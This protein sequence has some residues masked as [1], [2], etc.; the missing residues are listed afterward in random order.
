[1]WNTQPACN[2]VVIDH[3]AMKALVCLEDVPGE[4]S[5]GQEQEKTN[6]L[7]LV[8]TFPGVSAATGQIKAS[9]PCFLHHDASEKPSIFSAH[10]LT[11]PSEEVL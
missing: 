4:T 3:L 7:D 11:S 2:S 5:Q 9:E 6:E 10:R 1:M 8:E